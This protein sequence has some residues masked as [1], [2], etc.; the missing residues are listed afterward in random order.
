MTSTLAL[1][2]ILCGICF[3]LAFLWQGIY[4]LFFSP[5]RSVPGPLLAR[6]STKWLTI[7]DL[8]GYRTLTIHELHRKYGPTVRVAPNELS[9]SNSECVRE[10]YG[11]QT[12]FL[13]AKI[14]ETMS[15]PP[16]GIFS[17]RGK[18][19]HSQRR[20]LLSHAFA[21]SSLMDSEPLIRVHVEKVLR[22]VRSGAHAPLDV[23]QL[24]RR[25]A[26]DIVGDLFLGQSFAALDSKEPHQFME[27]MDKAFLLA[28]L[29]WTFPLLY[30]IF[31]QL[32]VRSLQHFLQA[33]ERLIGF[34]HD[35]FKRYLSTYG[36]QSGRKDLISKVVSLKSDTGTPPLT[37]RETF[38][39]IGNLVFAGSDTT[40]MTLTYMFWEL[41]QTSDWQ[42]KLR[43]E[44]STL[45][46]GSGG[47]VPAF[48]DLV[49]LP[50]LDAVV[51]EALRLH[52]AA[53]ASLPRETPRG[54]R[55][56]NGV[57]VPEGTVVSMQCY[58]TQRD[59]K[60]FR[61]PD[62]FDPSRW[63]EPQSDL[64]KELFMPF[65][66]GTRACL[67]KSLALMELKLI[68]ATL[69]K[70]F[71]VSLAPSCTKESMVMTDHFLVIPK[72]GRCELIFSP[73][74]SG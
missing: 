39:E 49:N 30:P 46:A 22:E 38:T 15:L 52:P 20:R 33:R 41:A 47:V 54:G 25:A 64:M 63:F 11:Q 37:D 71:T 69:L 34:G 1:G 35:A 19:E 17:M 56:L 43:R 3:V 68:T 65:S 32:P 2:A 36:R 6:L 74:K 72:G 26:F 73:I 66:K 59:P 21:Q 58:T 14:Y 8:G 7:V 45:P 62:V 29:Q 60:V 42:E 16:L 57:H 70:D 53:P 28:G 10:I 51:Q 9:F 27:D 48:T 23:M 61:N 40:S 18:E 50:I 13:K 44:L 4:N 31:T 67:G 24:F 12:N 5:L 55:L